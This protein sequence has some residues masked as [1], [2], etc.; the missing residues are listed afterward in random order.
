MKRQRALSIALLALTGHLSAIRQANAQIYDTVGVR[1]QG[2]AGAFVAVADDA[3]ATW[4]NPAGLA[5][6]HF[7][8]A[9]IEFETAQEPRRDRDQAGLA[10]PAWRTRNGGLAVAFPALGFS[11]Y[12]LQVSEIRSPSSTA[13]PDVGRQDQGPVSVLERTLVVNEFGATFDQSL[14][15]HV[16]VGTTLRLLYGNVASAKSDAASASLDRASD[17]SSPG[18][19]HPGIDVGVIGTFGLV[20]VGFAMRNLTEPSFGE[21]TDQVVLNR[22]ARIGMAAVGIRATLAIDADLTR[23][24]TPVG[25]ARHVAVGGE[26]PLINSRLTVRVGASANTIGDLRP[27]VSGG[28]S[29]GLSSRLYVDGEVTGGS[30]RARTGWGIDFRVAY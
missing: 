5:S 12:R 25:D 26:L 4:W 18:E 15:E 28:V 14:G 9:V 6:A 13:V 17:L 20:R 29:V 10:V 22:Q 16:V 19:T 7:F 24:P 11:Y 27:A 1:A 2:M 21:G 23:T 3:T 8:D 30:D